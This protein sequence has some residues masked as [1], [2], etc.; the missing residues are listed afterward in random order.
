MAGSRPKKVPLGD[1]IRDMINPA[2]EDT[3][4]KKMQLDMLNQ[5]FEKVNSK[6]AMMLEPEFNMVFN[7]VASLRPQEQNVYLIKA[8]TLGG[9]LPVLQ[10]QGNLMMRFTDFSPEEIKSLPAYV[11]LH[12]FLRAEN[13]AIKVSGATA[14]DVRSTGGMSPLV[15]TI[16][17][18]KSYDDG[19]LENSLLYPDLPPPPPDMLPPPDTGGSFKFGS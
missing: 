9:Y 1:R 4:R 7:H 19:A 17:A 2:M 10:M 13:I 16:D 6:V 12:E 3:R 18:S 5:F 8:L 15:V 11:M 14:D